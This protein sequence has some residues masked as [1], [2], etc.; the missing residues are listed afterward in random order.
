MAC[1]RNHAGQAVWMEVMVV[2]GGGGRACER[3]PLMTGSGM[4]TTLMCIDGLMLD[5]WSNSLAK[6]P[7]LAMSC[8]RLSVFT[9][10][11]HGSSDICRMGFIYSILICEISH[12]TSGPSHRKC[13]TC[14]MIFVNTGLSI[15]MG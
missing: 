1:W 3:N 5:H 10:N 13:P 6:A 11:F 8:V 14:P 7:Q 12:Q 15:S 4:G 2:G 9:K